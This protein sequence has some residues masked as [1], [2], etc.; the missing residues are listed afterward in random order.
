MD[1]IDA[2]NLPVA[3]GGTYEWDPEEWV[4]QQFEV[5]GIPVAK[6]PFLD[7]KHIKERL[8]LLREQI[9]AAAGFGPTRLV[10]LKRMVKSNRMTNEHCL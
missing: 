1:F 5:E 10:L 9:P 4:K 7:Q 8:E 3:Y 6:V 2:E